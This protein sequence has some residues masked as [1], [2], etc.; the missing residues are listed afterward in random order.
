M[1]VMKM[2]EKRDEVKVIWEKKEKRIKG[3]APCE[4]VYIVQI[5]RNG[6]NNLYSLL[7]VCQFRR[8][9]RQIF[10]ESISL[11]KHPSVSNFRGYYIENKFLYLC[12]HVYIHVA[13]W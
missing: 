6:T 12:K 1:H 2:R 4:T 10:Y 3:G 11:L 7:D 9:K 13:A 5:C 8:A